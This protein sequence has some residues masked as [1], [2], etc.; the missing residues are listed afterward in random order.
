[1][2]TSAIVQYESTLDDAVNAELALL[3]RSKTMQQSRWFG[4]LAWAAIAGGLFL[5][6]IQDYSI[7]GIGFSAAVAVLVAVIYLPISSWTL[8]HRLRRLCA[9][10]RQT[11]D[12]IPF[13]VRL[14]EQG[15]HAEWEGILLRIAW[16][17]VDVI[18]QNDQ[19]V[20][21]LAQSGTVVT[22]PSRAFSSQQDRI[23]F[24]GLARQLQGAVGPKAK[25]RSHSKCPACGYDVYGLNS[26]KCPEC[27][28]EISSTSQDDK[29]PDAT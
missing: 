19:G 29:P 22:V 28:A 15:V 8:K 13:Q 20:S 18:E 17:Q 11:S 7:V 23:A 1:M 27:G 9:D 16:S 21:F 25:A 6:V 10:L 4:P 26:N 3:R 12:S 2:A 24:T 14:D 5:I